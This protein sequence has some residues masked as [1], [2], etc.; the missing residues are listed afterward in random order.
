MTQQPL[1]VLLFSSSNYGCDCVWSDNELHA[2]LAAVQRGR[3]QSIH[4]WALMSG[5]NDLTTAW[6]CENWVG[7]K[8][9]RRSMYVRYSVRRCASM[10]VCAQHHNSEKA[11]YP[12]SSRDHR[13]QRSRRSCTTDYNHRSWSHSPRFSST[14]HVS[15]FR[16]IRL[17]RHL[18]QASDK[19][20]NSSEIR[21][22]RI[23]VCQ[24][25]PI[26]R[27]CKVVQGSSALSMLCLHARRLS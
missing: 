7:M 9:L 26:D 13:Y 5:S 17:P 27:S 24:V 20:L 15:Y 10:W 14:S 21:I 8:E 18:L 22:D 23:I 3:Q 4:W 16:S 1:I 2:Q 6:R 19:A 11:E 12:A 25:T